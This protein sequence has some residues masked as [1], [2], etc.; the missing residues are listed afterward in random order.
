M[1]TVTVLPPI[2]LLMPSWSSPRSDDRPHL[3]GAGLKTPCSPNLPMGRLESVLFSIRAIFKRTLAA[4]SIVD[5]VPNRFPGQSCVL[6]PNPSEGVGEHVWPSWL[7]KEFRG[8]GPFT[9][10][11]GGNPYPKRDGTPATAEALPSVHVPMCGECNLRLSNSIEVPAKSVIRKIL[12]KP[13]SHTWPKVTATEAE[14]LARWFLKVGLLNTHPE[15]VHDSPHVRKDKAFRRKDQDE[16]AWLQW[17]R[18]EKAPPTWFSVFLTRQSVSGG[19]SWGGEKILLELPN[20]SV[21]ARNLHYQTWAAGIRGIEATI[22]WHP[23][24]PILHPLVEEGRAV[25]LWP[26]PSLVDFTK[27]P[28]VHSDEFRFFLGGTSVHLADDERLR[29][30]AETPLQVGVDVTEHILKS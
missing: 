10:E 20:V 9:V 29:R 24:W 26:N 3:S 2:S 28:E 18:T 17:M 6:C 30:V 8:E 7:I 27:L 1:L 14:A 23:Y 4:T 5:D 16:P 15:A 11:K 25:R 12:P 19:Q 21:G 13:G 22:V